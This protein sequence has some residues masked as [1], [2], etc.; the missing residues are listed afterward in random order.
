M[1]RTFVLPVLA[2]ATMSLG[3]LSSCGNSNPITSIEA[4]A[5]KTDFKVDGTITKDDLT[6]T[7]IYKDN[8][9]KETDDFK[10]NSSDSYTF[11]MN[12]LGEKELY[13]YSSNKSTTVTVNVTADPTLEKLQFIDL[14]DQEPY[15]CSV[16]KLYSDI[17][18][19]VVIPETYKSDVT[20]KVYTVTKIASEGFKGSKKLEGIYFPK[21]LESIESNAFSGCGEIPYVKSPK[22]L[23]LTNCTKLKTIGSSAFY[24]FG[25]NPELP[26]SVESIGNAAFALNMAP[27]PELPASLEWIGVNAFAGNYNGSITIPKNVTYIGLEAFDGSFGTVT[28]DSPIIA[29]LTSHNSRLLSES[30]TK[31]LINNNINLESTSYIYKL[32]E[33]T[34]SEGNYKTYGFRYFLFNIIDEANKYCEISAG[35]CSGDVTIPSTATIN[36]V[37]YTVTQIAN[38]GF[39]RSGITAIHIPSTV[40]TIISSFRIANDLKYAYFASSVGWSAGATPLNRYDIEN[41]ETAATFL[42]DTYDLETWTQA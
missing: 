35:N 13:I 24:Q 38:L 32:Y 15:T 22:V 9:R 20:N 6:V 27:I 26:D 19:F 42:T 5:K 18:G 29:N 17:S 1:K 8:T 36:G 34:G 28:I 2:L 16:R 37:T 39:S 4:I 41:P 21:T 11:V 30:T 25:S 7:L 31:I 23:N 33:N 14:S 40:K 10:I 12:D 3:A